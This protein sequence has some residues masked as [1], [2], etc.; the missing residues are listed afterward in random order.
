MS[1]LDRLPGEVLA[2]AAG[3]FDT[4]TLL[5]LRLV[6]KSISATIH[7]TFL[8]RFFR[9]RNV[10]I[11]TESLENLRQVSLSET[12]RASVTSLTVCIHHVPEAEYDFELED[13]SS[14]ARS[15]AVSNHPQYTMLLRDQKW[16]MESGQATA[17]LALALKNLPNCTA[18]EVSDQLDDF[19]RNF[20][21]SQAGRLLTT[22]MKLPA[23]IDFVKQ[24]VS[25]ALAAINASGC[26][27][28]TFF[29]GH[30]DEGIGIQQ[31]PRL[32]SG[33][34]GHPFSNLP[35]LCLLLGLKFG[36]I[37][38]GWETCLLDFLKLFPSLKDLDLAF[39]PRLTRAQF[40]SIAQGLRI[41]GIVIL[42][43]GCVDCHYDDLSALIKRHRDTL[44]R[45]TLDAVDLTGYKKPWQR[46]L[47]FIRDETLMDSM[48]FIYCMSDDHDVCFGTHFEAGQMS[49]PADDHQFR[50]ELEA[51][52]RAL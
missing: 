45:I 14:E 40:S 47:Q 4:E 37:E 21:K 15:M 28:E 9:Y 16:L 23:S 48:E 25:T 24:L 29:I 46:F 26:T 44:R 42:H 3:F 18:V 30:V 35:S 11:S 13:M 12:Y 1:L 39:Q 2:E 41:E 20:Q 49:I 22:R 19:D 50:A 32:S 27:L 38:D 10:F 8:R 36:D 31:L 17:C 6:N 43:L 52:I 5:N 34:L 51:V 33:M 7:Y